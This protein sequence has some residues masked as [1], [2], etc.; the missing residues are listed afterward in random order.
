MRVRHACRLV[1]KNGTAM[2]VL[3]AGE[4]SRASGA[5]HTTRR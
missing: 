5:A 1:K 2:F 4:R 3:D